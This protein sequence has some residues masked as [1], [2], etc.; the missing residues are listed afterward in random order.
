[1][2][3]YG[4]GSCAE[5]WSGL[6]G[7][8]ARETALRADLG[9]LLD[10]RRRLSVPEYEAIETERTATVDSGDFEPALDGLGGWYERYYAGRRLLVFR[11]MKDY[12]RRYDW[13]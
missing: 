4:S 10:R 11:G 3:S 7:P 8:Q 9:A 12:Y 13:S 2:F 6:V 1:M 5:F